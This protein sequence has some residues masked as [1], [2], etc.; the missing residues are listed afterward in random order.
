VS[1]H[2]RDHSHVDVRNQHSQRRCDHHRTGKSRHPNRADHCGAA[3]RQ[4]GRRQ[5][6]GARQRHCPRRRRCRGFGRRREESS[7]STA[8]KSA[9]A[10][11]IQR[12]INSDQ[13]PILP[14][15]NFVF[16]PSRAF[17]AVRLRP[18]PISNKIKHVRFI[19]S[20]LNER[21]SRG[22]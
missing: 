2:R 4:D 12:R 15:D 22:S 18:S 13:Q 16:A 20:A 9:R 1:R 17:T 11:S 6:D 3:H 21:S 19:G 10:A 7:P 14:A 8:G 5:P